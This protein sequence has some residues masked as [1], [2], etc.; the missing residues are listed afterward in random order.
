MSTIPAPM[1]R[2]HLLP[3]AALL[4]AL[5]AL[6][7]FAGSAAAEVRAEEGT[8]PADS[9]IAAEADILSAKAEYDSTAGSV[10][11]A[12]TT[13]AAPR[14]GTEADP[15]ELQILAELASVPSCSIAAIE[16][17]GPE[18]GFPTFTFLAPYPEEE[19]ED[20]E[21]EEI[22]TWF[23]LRSPESTPTPPG[24]FG[25]ATK[26]VNGATTTLSATAP[27]AANLPFNCAVVAVLGAEND[28]GEEAEELLL[29]PLAL[30][31]P[32]TPPPPAA[33][34]PPASSPPPQP[35]PGALSITK[36]EKPLRLK[37]DKWATAKVKVTNTGGT[38]TA[39]GSL[40][41]KAVKGVI[42]KGG[43]QKLPVLLPG[44]SWTV[45]YKVKLTAKAKKASTLSLVGGAGSI[46]TKSSLALKLARG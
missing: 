28:K 9:T 3:T 16:S 31:T 29:F 44:E 27:K 46:S 40:Q 43:K 6:L 26:T 13:A 22:A 4:I 10:S 39:A 24:T 23:L 35:A 7:A 8:S 19:P 15:A 11:F 33:A 2:R 1:D 12:I 41:L 20:P 17:G 21:E 14:R 5:A 37:V 25:Y 18:V 36:G 34:T 32:V 42:V 45:S 30:V 38:M